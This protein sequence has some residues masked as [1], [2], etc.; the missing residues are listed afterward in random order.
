MKSCKSDLL[1]VLLKKIIS[2]FLEYS[3][4][5]YLLQKTIKTRLN[6]QRCWNH[7]QVRNFLDIFQQF[8]KTL[9]ITKSTSEELNIW[10]RSKIRLRWGCDFFFVI[11]VTK[12]QL[13]RNSQAEIV[14]TR[15]IV[16]SYSVIVARLCNTYLSL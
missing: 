9:L 11:V 7:Q 3:K 4:K 12:C 14:Y 10:L 6:M 8:N 15:Q 5:K 2:K 16:L 1:E 13:L